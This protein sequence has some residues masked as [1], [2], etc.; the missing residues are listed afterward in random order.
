MK[1]LIVLLMWTEHTE[2]EEYHKLQLSTVVRYQHSNKLCKILSNYSYR[3]NPKKYLDI[4]IFQYRT[5]LQW[6][7]LNANWPRSSPSTPAQ[8]TSSHPCLDLPPLADRKSCGHF[9]G[10]VIYGLFQRESHVGQ[11]NLSQG[12]T[13]NSVEKRTEKIQ[14]F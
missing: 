7:Q 13:T 1:R 10:P 6:R 12:E 14:K 4:I 11:P 2:Y 8:I 9:F 3:K 5:P